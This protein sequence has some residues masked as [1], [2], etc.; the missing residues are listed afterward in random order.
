MIR[1]QTVHLHKQI[2]DFLENLLKFLKHFWSQPEMSG[3]LTKY[4]RNPRSQDPAF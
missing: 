2:N 4:V 3:I 1:A